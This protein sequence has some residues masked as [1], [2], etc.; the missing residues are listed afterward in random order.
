MGK[1]NRL[2]IDMFPIFLRKKGLIFHANCLLIRKICQTLFSRGKYFKMSSAENFTLRAYA[3][4]IECTVWIMMFLELSCVLRCLFR[5][6]SFVK[7]YSNG[8]YGR[9]NVS[10]VAFEIIKLTHEK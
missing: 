6:F 9:I 3:L 1:Y 8:C 10:I 4:I 2:Q 5:V 7:F